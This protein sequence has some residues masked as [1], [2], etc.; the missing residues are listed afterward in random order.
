MKQ[1]NIESIAWKTNFPSAGV[2][3]EEAYKQLEK[4]RSKEGELTPEAVIENAKSNRSKLHKLFEWDDTEAAHQYR[5]EQARRMLRSIEIVY[6][7]KPKTP[8]RAFEIIEK[9]KRGSQDQRTIY[10]TTEEAMADPVS[11]DR[12]ITE[13]LRQLMAFRRRFHGLRELEI[14]FNSIEQA[15]DELSQEAVSS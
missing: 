5:M 7:E 6:K 11:R 8:R 14:V 3:A 10:S 15:I 1:F 12:I 13:A 9:K 4:I 2:S